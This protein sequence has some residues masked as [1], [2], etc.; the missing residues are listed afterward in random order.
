[1]TG[2]RW[3][4]MNRDKVNEMIRGRSRNPEVEDSKVGIG[5]NGG[6]NRRRVRREGGAIRA[7]VCWEGENCLRSLRI[8]L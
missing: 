6:Q 4:S 5:G 3:W 2:G 8:I 7:G 1:M